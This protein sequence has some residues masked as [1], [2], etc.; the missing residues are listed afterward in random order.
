MITVGFYGFMIAIAAVAAFLVL[1]RLWGLESA[2]IRLSWIPLAALITQVVLGKTLLEKLSY[3]AVV[4]PLITC[5]ASLSLTIVG[6]T[7]IASARQRQDSYSGLL[8][9]TLLASLPVTCLAISG[10]AEA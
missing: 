1:G 8:K 2:Y 4:P 6:V 5:F 7:L 9:A 3:A 10:P